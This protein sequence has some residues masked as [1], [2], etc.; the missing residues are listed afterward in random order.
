MKKVL[1]YWLSCGLFYALTV[2]T[3]GLSLFFV[4]NALRLYPSKLIGAGILILIF[5]LAGFVIRPIKQLKIQKVYNLKSWVSYSW[6][7]IVAAPVIAYFISLLGIFCTNEAS[8]R[9][10]RVFGDAGRASFVI[11]VYFSYGLFIL[12]ELLT[13][14]D[15]KSEKLRFAFG[16][17]GMRDDKFDFLPV[18]RNAKVAIES[19]MLPVNVVGLYG[20]LGSGKSSLARMI[21]E[22]FD[23]KDILYSYLSL[24]ETNHAKDFANLYADRW[25]EALGKRY[26]KIDHVSGVSLMKSVLRESGN[27]ILG[28]VI[29]WLVKF[30][31]GILA[32]KAST[33]SN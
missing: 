21:V 31:R 3:A 26:P 25:F 29:E 18:A 33:S 6:V 1:W 19:L 5:G 28:G 2:S 14:L 10:M 16:A 30:S 12:Y 7:G 24:T 20:G 8:V 11:H 15:V 23:H 22:Q 27:G 13:P 9:C 4:E 32:T 17:A